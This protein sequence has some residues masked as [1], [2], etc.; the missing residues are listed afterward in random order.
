MTKA[1]K[2]DT[3]RNHFYRVLA[4]LGIEMPAERRE[5]AVAAHL[6]LNKLKRLL[7]TPRTPESESCNIF[8][9]NALLRDK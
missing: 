2:H 3:A 8:S 5:G 1:E 6:E 7:R 4:E 9:L